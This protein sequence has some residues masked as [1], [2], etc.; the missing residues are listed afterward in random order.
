MTWVKKEL[1]TELDVLCDVS[2]MYVQSGVVYAA[3]R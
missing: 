1:K 3:I 2:Y